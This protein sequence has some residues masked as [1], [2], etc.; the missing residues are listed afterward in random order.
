[1]TAGVYL[2]IPF[3]RIRCPY[4]D[5]NTYTG[6]NDRIPDYVAALL[7]ELDQIIALLPEV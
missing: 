1:M 6:L 4:C 7:T 5:F 3:C 2:H